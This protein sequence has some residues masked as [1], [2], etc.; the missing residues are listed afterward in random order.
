MLDTRDE[1]VVR[2]WPGGDRRALPSFLFFFWLVHSSFFFMFS[3]CVCLCGRVRFFC[4]ISNQTS[5]NWGRKRSARIRSPSTALGSGRRS[6]FFVTINFVV[7]NGPIVWLL[8][9]RRSDYDS[10]VGQLSH[11]WSM[12]MDIFGENGDGKSTVSS[13][14]SSKLRTIRLYRKNGF[15][16]FGLRGGREHNIGFYVSTVIPGSES[17]LQG[18][19][20]SCQQRNTWFDI[21]DTSFST[22]IHVRLVIRWYA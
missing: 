4:Y 5:P 7:S 20:A 15:F 21:D 6:Y 18:L 16:G 11:S 19:S 1:L 2:C 9:R 10:V 14:K 12:M 17:E 8:G 3:V 22:Q 13:L